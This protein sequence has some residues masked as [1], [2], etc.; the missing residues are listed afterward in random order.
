MTDLTKKGVLFHWEEKHDDAFKMIKKLDK[1]VRFLQRI[2]YESEEPV[3]LIADAS[4]RG[5][6]GYVAQGQNWKTAHPIG[7]YSRQYR[8][9]E[10]NYPT[11][12]QEM[13]AII[14]YMKH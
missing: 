5:V 14:I 13:L 1:S 3:W 12:E 4:N 9:A 6:G 8:S 10:V 11:H 7:F 2:N